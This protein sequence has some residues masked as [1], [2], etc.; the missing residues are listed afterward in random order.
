V[1]EDFV[2]DFAARATRRIP[3]I[4]GLRGFRTGSVNSDWA[5]AD[6]QGSGDGTTR[7]WA[8]VGHTVLPCRRVKRPAW[9]SPDPAASAGSA[10]ASPSKGGDCKVSIQADAA[11]WTLGLLA[12]VHGYPRRFRTRAVG[13]R[14]AAAMRP[15][16]HRPD[17]ESASSECTSAAPRSSPYR[18]IHQFRPNDGNSTRRRA[19]WGPSQTYLC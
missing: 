1:G 8:V 2:V 7:A 14:G 19:L 15:F 6:S 9:S 18:D 3:K 12:T 11:D 5:S 13:P 17:R 10:H 16:V 4:T